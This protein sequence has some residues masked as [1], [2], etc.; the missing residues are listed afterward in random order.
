[1]GRPLGT[2]SGIPK[3]PVFADLPVRLFRNAMMSLTSLSLKS[4]GDRSIARS[5]RAISRL[6]S[7]T[8]K[9]IL[10]R[11][12]KSGNAAKSWVQSVRDAASCK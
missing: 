11:C 12:D 4:C 8:R 7:Q 3:M 9:S 6:S 5:K 2:V 10:E 1:M